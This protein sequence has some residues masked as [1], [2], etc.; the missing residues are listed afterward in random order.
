MN[1]IAIIGYGNLLRGD[2][3]IGPRAA[4]ILEEVYR[5]D[6]AIEVTATV[7]LKPE[8]A[9]T[10]ARCDTAIFI[11]AIVAGPPG[12]IQVSSVSPRADNQGPA[13][14]DFDPGVLLAL[15]KL[16]YGRCCRAVLVTVAG[17]EF[18]TPMQ[19]SPAVEAAVEQVCARV[20]HLVHSANQ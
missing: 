10:L 8:F 9:E 19:L 20:R 13:T 16:L 7:E 17:Q 11:D 4:E 2:D 6:A 15:A 3:A 18:G 12:A 5:N 1:S 14:H